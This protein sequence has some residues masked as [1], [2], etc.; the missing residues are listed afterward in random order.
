MRKYISTILIL[1]ILIQLY[2]CHS[3]RD[4][5]LDELKR[6][7]GSTDVRIKTNRDEVVINR[8]STGENSMKWKTGDS[9]IVIKSIE[10]IRDGGNTIPIAKS[11]EI[12]YNQIKSIEIEEYDNLKTTG[13]TVGIIAVVAFIIAAAIFYKGLY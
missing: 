4:I 12:E 13:L 2:G 7:D 3:F 6:Y 8:K 10:L 11:S 1:C 9:S 5:T